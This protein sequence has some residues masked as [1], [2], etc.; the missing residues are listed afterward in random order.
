MHSTRMFSLRA[1]LAAL[2]EEARP[3]DT[4][5]HGFLHNISNIGPKYTPPEKLDVA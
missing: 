4:G 5:E 2:S 3:V 1:S